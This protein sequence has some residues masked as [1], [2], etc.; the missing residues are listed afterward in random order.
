[1]PIVLLRRH[2]YPG[3]R[4]Y[5]PLTLFYPS[6]HLPELFQVSRFHVF[7]IYGV[8]TVEED[9]DSVVDP[10]HDVRPEETVS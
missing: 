10:I 4:G 1:M 7:Q 9:L 6:L 3:G 5:D 8:A 2:L